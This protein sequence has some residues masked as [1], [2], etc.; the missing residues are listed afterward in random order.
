[1]L[2]ITHRGLGDLEMIEQFSGL[3]GVLAR[4]QVH[5]TEDSHGPE[6]KIFEIADRRGDNVERSGVGLSCG[7]E[8][9]YD[10]SL[11]QSD[12][13]TAVKPGSYLFEV[14]G[15][16]V[17]IN[18]SLDV[19]DRLQQDV[20]RGFGAVPKRG[21][22]VGGI[23][24]GTVAQADRLIIGV[25][26]YEMAPIE[27]KRGPSYQ[28]SP[29]DLESFEAILDRLRTASG[30]DLKPVGFL[31]SHTREGAGLVQD[32]LD[33]LQRFFPDPNAIVLLI[34]PYATKVSTA[35]F[36]IRDNGQFPRDAPVVEFPFRR[37]DLAP[38][39]DTPPKRAKPKEDSVPPPRR[40]ATTR[41]GDALSILR[42]D[43]QGAGESNVAAPSYAESPE[44]RRDPGKE[45]TQSGWVW[46]PLSFIF[47]L[48]GVLLG[49]QAALTLRPQS[50]AGN[51]DPFNLQLN[52]SKEGDNL[53]VRWD[54]QARAVR[55]ALR[56]VLV[57]V[58]GVYNKTVELDP[59]QL[60]TGTVVYRHNSGEVR[61]RLEV[62]PRER[63]TIIETVDWKQ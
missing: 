55:S 12:S 60:Q 22:E 58:D 45:N 9:D 17:S 3:P 44:A 38:G 28:L 51:S 21:A 42:Y 39:E 46:V 35:T 7:Q 41:A 13:T 19:V 6:S 50:A 16:T 24:L 18:L 48:L 34:K 31:R 27:Y 53:N 32:D 49:F 37:R 26:D 61:F 1:M 5:R 8:P 2:V 36:L 43:G 29:A 56:G 62:Y 54:R 25:D 33:L 59:S 52:V 4:N 23:L 63:D 14:P 30:S 10:K 47:L 15:K 11:A 40:A 20:M 57:I